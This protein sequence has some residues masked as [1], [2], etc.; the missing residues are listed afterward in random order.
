MEQLSFWG[1]DSAGNCTQTGNRLV[2]FMVSGEFVKIGF[3]T[4]DVRTRKTQLNTGNPEELQVIGSIVV[5]DDQDDRWLHEELAPFQYRAEWFHLT[6]ESRAKIDN[7]IAAQHPDRR[8]TVD[9][10]MS[11]DHAGQVVTWSFDCPYCRRFVWAGAQLP[12]LPWP[13]DP[14]SGVVTCGSCK[15]QFG[16]KFRL[17]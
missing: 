6:P 8:R 16:V 17:P 5:R 2:Y 11:P 7:L 15:R 13:S 10:L 12:D 4:Q 1:I 3:T 9:A 14:G